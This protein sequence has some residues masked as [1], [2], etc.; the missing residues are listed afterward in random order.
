MLEGDDEVLSGMEAIAPRRSFAVMIILMSVGGVLFGNCSVNEQT[1]LFRDLCRRFVGTVEDS[2][3]VVRP[4][5]RWKLIRHRGYGER[6][7]IGS[8]EVGF[9]LFE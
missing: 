3:G 6:R 4:M 5:E 8:A 1:H 7:A 9:V 2:L